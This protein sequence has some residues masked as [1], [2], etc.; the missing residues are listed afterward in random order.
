MIH[1]SILARFRKIVPSLLAWH[2]A[3]QR[4][5][6]WRGLKRSPYV[7]LV[8]E[9]M[10]Q[11]TGAKQV[12][13]HLPEFLRR[14][15]TVKKLAA[16]SR[17]EVIRAWQGLGYNRRA[18]NLH[19]AAKAIAAKGRFP[20]ELKGLQGLRGVGIYTA[21]AVLAF[22]YN[23]DV[24]VVDVNIERVL[25]RLWK[26]MPDTHSTLPIRDVFDLDRLILPKGHSS[27]WHEALMDLGATVCTK[28]VPQCEVC[29]LRPCCPS[30]RGKKMHSAHIHT[31]REAR[32]FGEPRRIWRGRILQHI[33][34][35]EN[36]TK[37]ALLAHLKKRYA[38]FE[39]SFV[40][41]VASVLRMLIEEGF[42]TQT[43]KRA[44]HLANHE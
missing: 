29:P 4:S 5:F 44:F 8:S 39:P 7:V 43:K 31:N 10:L 6:I 32:Y 21:S 40:P 12:E 19:S 36:I 1:H 23:A 11:Q 26:Q 20:K 24:P 42:V 13:N 28:Q 38:I 18:I 25:S 35:N 22:A 41:F 27:A 2:R 14:F 9:F 16:A 33:S 37:R 3:N 15:P 34:K 17:P 30:G